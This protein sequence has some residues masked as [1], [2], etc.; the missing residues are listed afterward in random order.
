MR[1]PAAGSPP[2]HAR[3]YLGGLCTMCKQSETSS[4][5][6]RRTLDV[7]NQATEAISFGITNSHRRIEHLFSDLSHAVQQRSAASQHDATRELS[8]PTR[9][10]NLVRDV[11]QHFFSPRLENVA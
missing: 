3:A 4:G 2:A 7:F 6:P 9:V 1:Q 5:G 8:F 11:H 10:F